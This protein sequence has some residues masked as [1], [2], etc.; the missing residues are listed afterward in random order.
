MWD[1]PTNWSEF[2]IT[3]KTQAQEV[4]VRN[5]LLLDPSRIQR[6]KSVQIYIIELPRNIRLVKLLSLWSKVGAVPRTRQ[7]TH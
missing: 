2:L 6:N 1:Q 7:K 3:T 4:L 5:V